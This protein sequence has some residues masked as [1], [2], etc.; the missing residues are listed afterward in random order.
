MTKTFS[1]ILLIVYSLM[2]C[3]QSSDILSKDEIRDDFDQLLMD[4]RENYIYL[5]DKNIDLSCIRNHYDTLIPE[6]ENQ[7]QA[8]LFFESILNEFYDNHLILNANISS[9]YRLYAPIYLTYRNDGYYV[10]NVWSSNLIDPPVNLINSKVLQFNS[11][12]FKT[13][14]EEFPVFCADKNNRKVKTWIA[15]KIIAGR[16]DRPRLLTVEQVTGDVSTI[17]IDQLAAKKVDDLLTYSIRQNIGIIRIN[18]S[19]GNNDL[20]PAF[21]DVLNNL[22]E[23]KSIIIDL[24]NTINGGNTYVARALMGHFVDTV[25]DYQIHSTSEKEGGNPEI[26]RTWV[27]YVSPRKPFYNKPVFIIVGRWTGSM[28]EGLAVAFDSFEK[29][30]VLGT[31]MA[32]LGGEITHFPFRNRD[33]GYQIPTT[34]L[35]HT[36]GTLRENYV[37]KHHY[38]ENDSNDLINEI[39]SQLES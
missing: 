22:I 25:Q 1:I 7:K 2:G 8:L 13:L 11:N 3:Q 29:A 9:S 12:D 20:I 15:N 17:D 36:N 27:E 34:K 33:Y 24:R 21:D 37:P 4:L 16:Y 30:T 39:L 18:N 31:E 32:G 10:S 6:I 19:L 38:Y 26:N 28:G 14:I 35:Y 5:N 23:T